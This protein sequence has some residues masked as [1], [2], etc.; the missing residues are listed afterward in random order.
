MKYLDER[1]V[2]LRRCQIKKKYYNSVTGMYVG[3]E[4]LHFQE[5]GLPGN[6][7]VK[8]P[9]N[10]SRMEPGLAQRKYPSVNRPQLILSN[11]GGTVNITFNIYEI[12][13][14]DTSSVEDMLDSFKRIVQT[15]QPSVTF[16]GRGSMETGGCQRGWLEFKSVSLDGRIYNLL[17]LTRLCRCSVLGMFN[18]PDQEMVSWRPVFLEVAATIVEKEEKENE[19]C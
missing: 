3:E 13:E 16:A 1:L 7:T 18:C 8:I 11:P 12:L 10:F 2:M 4:L 6:G 17:S 5:M 9:E 15:A 14:E 19:T